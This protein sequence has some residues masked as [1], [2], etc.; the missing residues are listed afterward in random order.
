MQMHA[1]VNCAYHAGLV[2]IEKQF[3]CMP[4]VGLTKPSWAYCDEL[5][6]VHRQCK[7]TPC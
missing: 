4:G 3:E 5:V 1:L 6:G 7:C 2:E